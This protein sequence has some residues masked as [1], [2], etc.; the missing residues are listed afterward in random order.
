MTSISVVS[1]TNHELDPHLERA[2]REVEGGGV[3]HRERRWCGVYLRAL[4]SPCG[5]EAA[6]QGFT[7]AGGIRMAWR[8]NDIF[9]VP[10]HMW[11][12][13]V[14]QAA[15]TGAV[16]YSVTDAPLLQSIGQYGEQGR[17]AAGEVIELG[18]TVPR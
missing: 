15:D 12:R 3:H 13:H 1:V 6:G 5:V 11:R 2:T 10:N 18:S 16:L 7:E 4:H 9:I 14:N 17:T 8:E